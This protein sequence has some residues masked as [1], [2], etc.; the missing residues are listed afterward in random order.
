MYSGMGRKLSLTFADTLHQK[1]S[2]EER[3]VAKW[4]RA[5]CQAKSHTCE[6][7]APHRKGLS[8][9]FSTVL[10]T[11]SALFQLPTLTQIYLRCSGKKNASYW[12]MFSVLRARIH[13]EYRSHCSIWEDADR[14]IPQTG[15][16]ITGDIFALLVV[17]AGGTLR[18]GSLGVVS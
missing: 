2:E 18:L 15:T 8:V 16:G 3:I 9:F 14:V 11:W 4:K 13:T 17:G 1:G 5:G 7:W 6:V 10:S 12:T